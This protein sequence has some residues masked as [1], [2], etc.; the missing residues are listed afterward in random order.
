MEPFRMCS[1]CR[2]EYEDVLDRRFHA[3]PVACNV[4]GPIYALLEN[5][6]EVRDLDSILDSSAKLLESGKIVAIKGMGGFQ[7]AC[8]AQNEAADFS[9]N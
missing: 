1:L 8:D 6:G 4:C 9:Q 5:G 3:Q 7:L 2:R